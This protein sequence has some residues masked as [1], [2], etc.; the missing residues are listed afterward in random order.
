MARKIEADPKRGRNLFTFMVGERLR[1]K[2]AA[3]SEHTARSVLA[4][5]EIRLEKS[6]AR[7][8]AID[9]LLGGQDSGRLIE[10]LAGT[11]RE[12]PHWQ[13]NKEK[14]GR[15]AKRVNHLVQTAAACQTSPDRPSR[16]RP[17]PARFKLNVR[18]TRELREKLI[19][20]AANS[21]RSIVKELEDRIERS[22]DRDVA[23]DL[24]IEE[25]PD[26]KLVQRFASELR[27]HQDWPQNPAPLIQS[28]S[29]AIKEA[30]ED[31]GPGN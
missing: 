1:D 14:A 26:G 11:V 24:L 5:L 25:S 18:T 8:V 3:A 31:T 13:R 10:L 28:L 2:V 7:D 20:A 21:G 15:L 30:R 16:V 17:A 12:H 9:I 23:M 22:F 19:A 4:E 29:D 27:N 6:F